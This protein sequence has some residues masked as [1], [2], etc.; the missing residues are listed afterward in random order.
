MELIGRIALIG[1]NPA[2]ASVSNAIA[3]VQINVAPF[4]QVRPGQIVSHSLCSLSMS[5]DQPKEIT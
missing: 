2:I 1:H 3:S 5:G 4:I